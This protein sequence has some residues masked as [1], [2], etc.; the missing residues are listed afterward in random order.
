MTHLIKNNLHMKQ[1]I[2]NYI[3][4]FLIAASLL[5]IVFIFLRTPKTI[6]QSIPT[7][8]KETNNTQKTAHPKTSLQIDKTVI[9]FGTVKED[10]VLIASYIVKNTGDSLLVIENINPDCTCTSYQLSKNKIM[11]KDTCLI[12][13]FLD[14]KG[15]KGSE[16]IYATLK[17][18]TQVEQYLLTLKA[19][20]IPKEKHI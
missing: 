15:K 14:T 19:R 4:I 1:K 3:C 12:L 2:I 9:D 13:L 18:N 6:D 10:S 7:N 17:A 20:V 5:W 8:T 16:I 11:P